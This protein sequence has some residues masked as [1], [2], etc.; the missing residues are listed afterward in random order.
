MNRDFEDR[1]EPITSGHAV[2]RTAVPVK[3]LFEADPK[4]KAKFN[5]PR[6]KPYLYCFSGPDTHAIVF[7]DGETLCWS[8]HHP[9]VHFKIYRSFIKAYISYSIWPTNIPLQSPGPRI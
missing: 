7:C 8:I 1:K 6:D 4:L 5:C 9:G 2:Y 3:H